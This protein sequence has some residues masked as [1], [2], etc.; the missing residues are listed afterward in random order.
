M[1]FIIPIYFSKNDFH[2]NNSL[3]YNEYNVI[4]IFLFVAIILSIISVFFIILNSRHTLLKPYYMEGN[5]VIRE[6]QLI[7]RVSP[8]PKQTKKDKK[9]YI[10]NSIV[11]DQLYEDYCQPVLTLKIFSPPGATPRAYITKWGEYFPTDLSDT[12]LRLYLLS[13]NSETPFL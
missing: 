2:F 13:E 7:H 10:I 1:N 6:Q 11:S 3:F 8:E 4:L 5:N 9:Y 12:A